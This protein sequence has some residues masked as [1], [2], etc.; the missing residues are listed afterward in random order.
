MN[1]EKRKRQL[2][3]KCQLERLETRWLMRSSPIEVVNDHAETR[4]EIFAG[5]LAARV[6]HRQDAPLDLVRQ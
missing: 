4:A 6:A 5:D 2:K 1:R 3:V